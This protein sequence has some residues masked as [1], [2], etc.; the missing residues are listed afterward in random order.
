MEKILHFFGGGGCEPRT[1]LKIA[2][3]DEVKSHV[4]KRLEIFSKDGGYIFATIHNILSDVPPENIVA[5]FEAIDEFY[6][7]NYVCNRKKDL[8]YI[9]RLFTFK[10]I[11]RRFNFWIKKTLITICKE[12][13]KV[14]L[15]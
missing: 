12:N 8:Q 1:I 2:K 7:Q 3:P 14:L 13:Y 5:L 11:N 10:Q 4:K 6:Q 15:L 9:V